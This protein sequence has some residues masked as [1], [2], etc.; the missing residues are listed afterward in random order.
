MF[1]KYFS[2]EIYTNNRGICKLAWTLSH[3]HTSAVACT[4]GV[5]G[6]DCHYQDGL[7]VNMQIGG[8][9]VTVMTNQQGGW[10]CGALGLA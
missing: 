5:G 10:G 7:H 2:V 6:Q 1:L 9:V 4:A 3:N 8:D